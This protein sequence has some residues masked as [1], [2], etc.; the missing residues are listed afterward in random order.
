MA[1]ADEFFAGEQVERARRY[2][3]P[4]NLAVG[5]LEDRSALAEN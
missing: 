4:L 5:L 3:R 1:G 2:H